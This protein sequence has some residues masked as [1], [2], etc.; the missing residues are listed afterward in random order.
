VNMLPGA[1][2]VPIASGVT[3]QSEPNV[4]LSVTTKGKTTKYVLTVPKG[5]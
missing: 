4:S 5:T 1:L 3:V 2:I